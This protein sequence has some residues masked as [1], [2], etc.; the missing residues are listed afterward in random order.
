MKKRKGLN[1]FKYLGVTCPV[2]SDQLNLGWLRLINSV[3]SSC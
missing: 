1:H 2:F 3:D